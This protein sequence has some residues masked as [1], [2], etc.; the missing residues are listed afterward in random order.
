MCVYIIIVETMLQLDISCQVKPPVSEMGYILLRH[1]PVGSHEP[2]KP[3]QAIIKLLVYLHN[4][5]VMPYCL[6]HLLIS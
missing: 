4:L 2:H 6:R 1:W 5:M 3:S